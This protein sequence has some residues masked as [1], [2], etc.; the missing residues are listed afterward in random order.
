MPLP[1]GARGWE[2]SDDDVTKA[3]FV[4]ASFEFCALEC[5]DNAEFMTQYRRLSGHKLGRVQRST[6]ERMVDE[7]CGHDP[8][9]LNDTEVREFL[10]FVRN[11]VWQPWITALVAETEASP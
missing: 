5:W 1:L 2:V 3:E 8:T 6:I 11:Y 9:A 4:R 7:A 10:E